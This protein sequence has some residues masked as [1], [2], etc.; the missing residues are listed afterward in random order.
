MHCVGGKMAYKVTIERKLNDKLEAIRS[1]NFKEYTLFSKK[2]EE[3]QNHARIMKNHK[4]KFNTFD[5][6]LQD[7]KWIE[8]NDRIIVFTIDPLRQ[9]MHLCDYLPKEDVFE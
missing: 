3:M 1:V 4:T 8:F 7:F 5:K 2:V 9:E 6:P